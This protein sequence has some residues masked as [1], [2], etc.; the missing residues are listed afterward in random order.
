MRGLKVKYIVNLWI[1]DPSIQGTK[2]H[3]LLCPLK[4]GSTV[5]HLMSFC[6]QHIQYE[7]GRFLQYYMYI[8]TYNIYTYNIYTYNIYTYNI[9][10]YNIYTYYIYTYYI[11]TYYIYTHNIYT[12]N[13]YTYYISYIIICD[14]SLYVWYLWNRTRFNLR[15]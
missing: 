15:T 6:I 14:V 12:Y 13:I 5:L 9:Y 7:S 2:Y 10:T 4:R 11:Y 8:Y 3:V 1:K